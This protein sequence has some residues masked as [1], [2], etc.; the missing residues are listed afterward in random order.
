MK[1][2][3]FTYTLPIGDDTVWVAESLSLDGCVAQ[4]DTIEDAVKELESNEVEWIYAAT[5]HNIPI[6]P[7]KAKHYSGNI[8]LRL[9]P[10]EHMKAAIRAKIEG[11]SLNQY[12]SNAVIAKNASK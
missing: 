2:P 6:P 3:Y 7:E 9:E 4:G 12:I 11:I 5:Q 1:Y 10:T 8:A